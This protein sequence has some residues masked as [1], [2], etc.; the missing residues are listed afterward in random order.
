M[1][2]S[3]TDFSEGSKSMVSNMEATKEVLIAVVCGGEE[4]WVGFVSIFF[5]PSFALKGPVLR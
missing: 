1:G 3:F 2:C 5:S 4:G